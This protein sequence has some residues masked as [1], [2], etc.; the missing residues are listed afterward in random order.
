MKA[1]KCG[2]IVKGPR[3]FRG[4]KNVLKLNCRGGCITASLGHT[5]YEG[6]AWLHE[7]YHNTAIFKNFKNHKVEKREEKCPLE[8]RTGCG[9]TRRPSAPPAGGGGHCVLQKWLGF[10]SNRNEHFPMVS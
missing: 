6:K 8:G 4:D 9:M 3:F 10:P 2:V 7:S 1:Q 5:V